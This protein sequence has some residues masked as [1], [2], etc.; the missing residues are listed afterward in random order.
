MDQLFDEW[1]NTIKEDFKKR[2]LEPDKVDNYF[3]YL[4]KS[5][6]TFNGIANNEASALTF[7]LQ[8]QVIKDKDGGKDI[9]ELFPGEKILINSAELVLAL[10]EYLTE[11][12]E[13]EIATETTLIPKNC[14][15]EDKKK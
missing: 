12:T 11:E 15:Y 13:V 2:G 4:R 8:A 10:K 3:D 9:L 6:S 14:I 5:Y 7:I 1:S